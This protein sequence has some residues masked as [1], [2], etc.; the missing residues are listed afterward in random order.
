MQNIYEPELVAFD[1]QEKSEAENIAKNV[2][3]ISVW[4]TAER[5]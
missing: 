5:P 4:A 2:I 3:I 1:L